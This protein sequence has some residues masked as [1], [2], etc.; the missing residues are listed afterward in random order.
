MCLKFR[1][2]MMIIAYLCVFVGSIYSK[3]TGTPEHVVNFHL[4]LNPFAVQMLVI[5]RAFNIQAAVKDLK[6]EPIISFKD[7]WD[8][9][10][11]WFKSNWLP[12]FVRSKSTDS[13]KNV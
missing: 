9:T 11:A 3:I 1:W 13:K 12:G 4:K 10:I 7:G 6:Y 5:D 2:F 8:E